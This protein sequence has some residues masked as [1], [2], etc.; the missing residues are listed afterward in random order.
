M[1]ESIQII[2]LPYGRKIKVSKGANL[3]KAANLS[4]IYLNSVCGGAGAC[5]KCEVLIR[6]GKDS[7][8]SSL[9]KEES[10][11][12]ASRLLACQSEVSGDIV[13]EVPRSSVTPEDTEEKILVDSLDFSSPEECP[14]QAGPDGVAEVGPSLTQKINLRMSPPTL[15]DTT[16]DL[17]RFLSVLRNEIHQQDVY[18]GLNGIRL[19]AAV[20]RQGAWNVTATLAQPGKVLARFSHR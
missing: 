9:Q 19:L 6:E 15:E 7:V 17:E 8:R 12:G 3:L 5:G 16:A 10:L 4:G 14:C 13:V 11:D 2:F 1:K 20:L 18:I